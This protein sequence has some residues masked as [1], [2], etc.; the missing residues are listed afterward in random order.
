LRLVDD[1]DVVIVHDPVACAGCGAGL[2]GRPGRRVRRRQSFD[3]PPVRVIVTEHQ[4]V[5]RECPC[6]VMTSGEAPAGVNCP[7]QYGPR[8]SAIMVYLY[9]GQFLS[10]KRTAHALAELF[11]TPV[12]AGTVAAV[13]ERAAAGLA[14]FLDIVRARIAAAPVAHFDETGLRVEG[15]L[16]WVHSASTDQYSLITVHDKR[17][18]VAMDDAGVL[19][20]FTGVAVHDAWAPYDTYTAATHALCNAHVLRE[21]QAVT[22]TIGAGTWSWAG[23]AADALLDMKKLTETRPAT[24]TGAGIDETGFADALRRYR[25]A[26]QIGARSTVARTSP[27]QKKHH[28]LARR[29]IDREADYLRFTFNPAVPFDNNAAER[30]IR[31]IKVKQKVSGCLRTLTGAANFVAIRS[32]LAT[33]QKHDIGFFHA[34]TRLAEG[35]CWMPKP[36]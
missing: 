30:E 7:V 23:Q 2:A 12:S 33:A 4:L 15:R 26:A 36:A 29:L 21:L 35:Q 22:D 24:H 8:I 19:P 17:G 18:R 1:P 27:I 16:R 11:G 32:Y 14:G 13:T 6:G 34:L 3:I 20:G 10:K 25:A 28:A 5:E 9:A 31:M